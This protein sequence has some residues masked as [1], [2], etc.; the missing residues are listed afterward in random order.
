[1]N[2]DEKQI[3]L[4]TDEK[5]ARAIQLVIDELISKSNRSANLQVEAALWGLGKEVEDCYE[6]LI[7]YARCVLRSYV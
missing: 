5:R 6:E 2:Q 3:F 7:E 1:M 4:S